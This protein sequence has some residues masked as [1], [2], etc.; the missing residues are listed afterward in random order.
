MRFFLM[1]VCVLGVLAPSMVFSAVTSAARAD[2][3]PL[4]ETEVEG[5]VKIVEDELG[6]HIT[7]EISGLT[8][9]G[10]HGF[11]LH[12]FGDCSAPDGMDAD[13]MGAGGHFNPEGH[14]HAGPNSIKRHFGDFGNIKADEEGVAIIDLRIVGRKGLEKAFGRGIIIHEGPD[15]EKTNHSGNAGARVACGVVGISK[16]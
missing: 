7:G 4:G 2:I 6:I 15:D 13:G 8:P 12:E 14:A 3:Y 9:G 16:L 10:L 1:L 11:H 5:F